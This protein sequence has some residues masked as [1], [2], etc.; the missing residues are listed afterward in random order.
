MSG[1]QAHGVAILVDEFDSLDPVRAARRTADFVHQLEQHPGVQVRSPAE[2][3]LQPQM[4]HGESFMRRAYE[5]GNSDRPAQIG[6]CEQRLNPGDITH[7]NTQSSVLLEYLG[8]PVGLYGLLDTDSY[9]M[10][11]DVEEQ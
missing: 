2:V 10:L 7:A 1:V 11:V 5:D 9:A 4:Q 8:H 3:R 6:N